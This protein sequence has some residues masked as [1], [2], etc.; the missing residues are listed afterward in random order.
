[1]QPILNERDR[2][3]AFLKFLLLFAVTVILVVTSVFFN[4][5]LPDK[6][7][8]LYLDQIETQQVYD[9][10]QIKFVRKMEKAVDLLDSLNRPVQD[11]TLINGELET[12]M[13]EMYML[14][15]NDKTIYGK[16]NKAIVLKFNELRTST[17]ELKNLRSN[18]S[19]MSALEEKLAQCER[20]L[21][22]YKKSQNNQAIPLEY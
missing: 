8:A 13:K 3:K 11:L 1:M 6:E 9:S 5:R 15:Q 14:Q 12:L 17:L 21:Q 7:N 19:K 2:T 16:M 20:D 18:S 4:Y 10:N 22:S